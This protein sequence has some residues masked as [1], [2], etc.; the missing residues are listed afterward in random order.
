M[1]DNSAALRQARRADGRLKR[2]HALQAVEAIETSG[3]PITFPAVARRARVSVSLL[4][5]DRE[6]A[7]RI[8][9]ARDRQRQAGRDRAW[10]LP[11]RSLVTEASLRTELANAKDQIRRLTEEIVAL[12][13]RLARQLGAEADAARGLALAPALDELEQ[14]ATDLEAENHLQRQQIARLEADGRELTETLEAAR[15]MNRE[16]MN[17]VN[18]RQSG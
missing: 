7:G 8:A 11:A 1:A 14:R 16:L 18:R 9:A 4:Y 5:A 3:S 15:A 17:E 6:L 12:R 2:Q 10:Q 13:Q